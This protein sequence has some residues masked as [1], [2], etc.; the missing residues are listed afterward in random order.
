MLGLCGGQS[1]TELGLAHEYELRAVLVRFVRGADPTAWGI[2]SPEEPISATQILSSVQQ[3][4]RPCFKSAVR[5][6]ATAR[7]PSGWSRASDPGAVTR[8]SMHTTSAIESN[9]ENTPAIAES[10]ISFEDLGLGPA[11]LVAVR[12]AGYTHPTPI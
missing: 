2:G 4:S 10:A 11:L 6:I 7:R 8:E 5:D 12:E 9:N 1:R 3:P